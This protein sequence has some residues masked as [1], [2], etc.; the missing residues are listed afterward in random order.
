MQ[1]LQD[2]LVA[3]KAIIAKLEAESRSSH[4]QS[5]VPVSAAHPSSL[6]K[7]QIKYIAWQAR[8]CASAELLSTLHA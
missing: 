5:L 1:Q 7:P 8:L 3:S 2:E 6:T 4:T